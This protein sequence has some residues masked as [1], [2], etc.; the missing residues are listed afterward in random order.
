MTKI[1]QPSL[2]V[3]GRVNCECV[4]LL[5]KSNKWHCNLP[6]EEVPL[7]GKF[8][9]ITTFPISLKMQKSLK[10]MVILDTNSK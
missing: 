10:G 9:K 8:A 7:Y 4:A 1:N 3:S 2:P 6:T 5:D